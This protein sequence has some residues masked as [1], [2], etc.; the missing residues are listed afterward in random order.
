MPASPAG[1][2]APRF[3]F[4][5]ECRLLRRADF[6]AAY[7]NG[8]RSASRQFVIFAWRRAVDAKSPARFGVSVK[9]ALGKA[10][11]RNRIRRRIREILRHCRA[12]LP[13]GWDFVIHPRASVATHAFA[14]LAT[15]LTELL[16]RASAA[17][18]SSE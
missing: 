16:R 8:R 6:E 18:K 10:V 5:R 11:K 17:P 13:G 14:A 12:E 15:E 4:P 2:A 7:R 1:H 9:R 3:S